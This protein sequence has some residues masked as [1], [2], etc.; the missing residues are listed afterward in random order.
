MKQPFAGQSAF[1]CAELLLLVCPL[2]LALHLRADV[3]E[4]IDK[5]ARTRTN[6]FGHGGV[7]APLWVPDT[8]SDSCKLCDANFTML[9]RRHHCR[10]CGACVCGM[11]S[12][13]D[14]ILPHISAVNRVRVCRLCYF[15][16]VKEARV[17]GPT[18]AAAASARSDASHTTPL[19]AQRK[20]VP[21]AAAPAAAS[22]DAVSE[23]RIGAEMTSFCFGC[24]DN[25]AKRT[26][27]AASAWNAG[28]V[29]LAERCRRS[30][31]SVAAP[32]F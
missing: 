12:A 21:V 14:W 13:Y 4:C 8:E 9:K 31:S 30:Y 1:A 10:H 15:I 29:R 25:S 32:V 2:Y 18:A 5:F 7:V 11:C 24:C 19:D 17:S 23:V 16:L 6:T 22:T 20:K 26:G 27:A 3:T 28:D